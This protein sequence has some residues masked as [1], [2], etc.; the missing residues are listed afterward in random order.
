MVSDNA[1]RIARIYQRVST[2]E[3]DLT[4]QDAIIAT[5]KADGW[6]IA[7]VYREK[8]SGADPTRPELARLV[9]DLQS[10]EVVIA[11]HLDRI[12]RLPLPEA[13]LLVES[14]RSKGAR[15]SVPGLVDLSDVA[16]SADG[17]ARIVIDA[18]QELLLRI[19]LQIARDD[20]LARRERQ[21][22]GVAIAKSNGVYK[23]RRANDDLHS[24]IV[25][26]RAAGNTITGTARMAK[27]SISLVKRVWAAHQHKKS[28]TAKQAGR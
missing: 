25:T 21:R 13:E 26:L 23:G 19:A 12:S 18:M 3:Q 11:E 16:S 10:G 9:A 7:G 28:T 24:T 20:Y 1:P 4:R 27:C 17:I 6:Y 15:L 8:A 22:Q 5:A 14:I 2:A